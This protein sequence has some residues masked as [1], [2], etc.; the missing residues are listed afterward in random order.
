MITL[1][2]IRHDCVTHLTPSICCTCRFSQKHK[3]RSQSRISL[4]FVVVAAAAAPP[5]PAT[6]TCDEA[7][8]GI[9]ALSTKLL[10]FFE[11]I[12]CNGFEVYL[13]QWLVALVE[14]AE[15][16]CAMLCAICDAC[17][18]ARSSHPTRNY[19]Q[20]INNAVMP[21]TFKEYL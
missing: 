14:S 12:V 19:V 3:G 15:C 8:T 16:I 2:F 7:E 17:P 18:A 9:A 21:Q 1:S 4:P 11:V 5:L 10:P 20:K 6:D 13:T